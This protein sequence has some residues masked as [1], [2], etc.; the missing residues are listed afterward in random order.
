MHNNTSLVKWIIHYILM[1]IF[2]N[3]RNQWQG[4]SSSNAAITTAT[5]D[6]CYHELKNK[7]QTYKTSLFSSNHHKA[8]YMPTPE[9]TNT[10]YIVNFFQYTMVSKNYFIASATVT[11]IE[12]INFSKFYLRI[13][14]RKKSDW[15]EMQKDDNTLYTTRL[16]IF[17]AIQQLMAIWLYTIQNIKIIK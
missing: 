13:K 7:K 15:K 9:R 17:F 1:K 11:S 16:N 4:I 6:K 12:V 14:I 3:T 5:K 8:I 2:V 10:G